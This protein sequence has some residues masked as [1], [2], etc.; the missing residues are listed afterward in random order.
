[1][2]RS[3]LWEFLSAPYT[4]IGG[5]LGGTFLTMASHGTDQLLVQRL[6]G[7]KS[8]R[9][10]QKALLLDASFIVLQ[11]AFFLFLGTC[12]YAFY[13]GVPFQQLGLQSSDE[14]FP[15]FI[16]EELPHGFS[17]IVKAYLSNKAFKDE[18]CCSFALKIIINGRTFPSSEIVAS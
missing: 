7:C 16:I 5:V 12:L 17:G 15:K 13:H 14:I 4:L 8:K 6:L 10:S 3:S 1:M 2:S 18:M 9:E 11:F